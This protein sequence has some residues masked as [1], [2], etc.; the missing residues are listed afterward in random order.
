MKNPPRATAMASGNDPD[1]NTVVLAT[2]VVAACPP[3]LI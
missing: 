1:R 3:G 2:I